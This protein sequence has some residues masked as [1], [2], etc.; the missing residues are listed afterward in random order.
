MYDLFS[1]S[2]LSS[3]T[4]SKPQNAKTLLTNQ[5]QS[6]TH[7]QFNSSIKDVAS[8]SEQNSKF[9][10]RMEDFTYINQNLTDEKTSLFCVFDGHGGVDTVKYLHQRFPAIFE[11]KVKSNQDIKTSIESSFNKVDN[12][13]KFH[14]S[15][16]EGSTASVLC[17]ESNTIHSANVGDSRTVLVNLKEKSTCRLTYDHKTTDEKERQRILSLGGKVSN[18]RVNGVL[19]LTRSVGDHAMRK[20]GVTAEPY[21]QCFEMEKELRNLGFYFIVMAS[22]G[23]WDVIKDEDLLGFDFSEPCKDLAIKI[24]EKSMKLGSQDNICCIVIKP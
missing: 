18:N 14:D 11:S 5:N 21:Y 3:T 13:L 17:I 19:C 8:H 15:N 20:H 1:S 23:V 22:D 16:N 7:N 4:T 6:E 24:V 9:K 10:V 2:L 12:E